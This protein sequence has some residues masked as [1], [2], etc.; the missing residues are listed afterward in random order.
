LGN[1]R[2]NIAGVLNLARSIVS[3]VIRRFRKRAVLELENLALRHQLYV[4][5]RQRSGWPRLFAIDRWLWVWRVVESQLALLHDAD[6]AVTHV[7]WRMT[8]SDAN[9]SLRQIP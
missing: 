3:V 4:L 6:E 9:G 2:S 8:Q 7:G 5:R 1:H